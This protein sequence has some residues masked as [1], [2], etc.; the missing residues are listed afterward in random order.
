MGFLDLRFVR[1]GAAAGLVAAIVSSLPG[2][3]DVLAGGTAWWFPPQLIATTVGFPL[4][5]GF[6]AAP[7]VVGGCLHLLISAGL[8]TAFAWMVGIRRLAPLLLLGS[9]F[10][11]LVYGLN[12]LVFELGLFST[13]ADNTK[14]AVELPAHLVF[15]ATVG[16]SLALMNVKGATRSPESGVRTAP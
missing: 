1:E 9:L 6:D 2:L 5:A 16:V 11:L 13:L 12:L 15:G 7:F 8:A 10:G 4:P 3:V 14:V